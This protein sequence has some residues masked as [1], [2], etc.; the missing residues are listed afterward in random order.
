MSIRPV[1]RIVPE[2]STMK[3]AGVTLHRAFGFGN[4]A[5]CDPSLLFDDFR[6]IGHTTISRD[7]PG[8]ASRGGA[9]DDDSRMVRPTCCYGRKREASQPTR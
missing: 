2:Q 3:G 5:E 6:A 7:F 1:S 9:P 8:T 4:T